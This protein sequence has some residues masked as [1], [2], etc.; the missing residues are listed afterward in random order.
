MRTTK[1][2]VKISDSEWEIMRVVWHKKAVDA[3]TIS[4]LL[5]ESKGWKIATVKTLLG[6]LV[7]KDVLHTE[8]VGK[9][10][11]YSALITEEETVRSATANLFSHICAV[12]AGKTIADWISEVDLTVD[13]IETIQQV[14][15]EKQAVSSI[16]CDCLP[17]QCHCKQ[18]EEAVS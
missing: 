16:A 14:L 1:E 3:T 7:K 8:Q 18:E 6:R 10:F 12:K 15:S 11:V 13:D 2:P 17:G 9:K 4:Q 5:S